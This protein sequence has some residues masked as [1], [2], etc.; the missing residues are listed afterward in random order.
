ML[1]SQDFRNSIQETELIEMQKVRVRRD[2]PNG[3]TWAFALAVTMLF[4]YLATL[5]IPEKDAE[6]VG[7]QITRAIQ[8][9]PVSAAFVSLGAYPDA[10]NARVAAAEFMQRGAAGFVLMHEGKYHVLGAAYQDLASA[11]F[12]ADALSTREKL[13]AAAFTIGEDGAKI[14]VTAPEFAVNAIADA[15]S[16][17][18]IQL[19]QLGAIA[20]RLDRNQITAPQARTLA[21]VAHSELHRAET[22]LESTAGNALCQTLCAN[23]IA[24]EFSLQSIQSLE[25]AAEISGRLRFSQIQGLLGEIELLKS[26]NSSAK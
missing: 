23:L 26:V 20:D 19:G 8:L 6:P 13:P 21:A 3:I 15:E 4:V 12:Q 9:E 18:R 16:T 1:Q 17:L 11:K 5:A 7:A 22:A 25:T 14:R 2:R 10:L 24:I